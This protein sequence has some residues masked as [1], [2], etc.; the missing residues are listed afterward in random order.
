M[1][2][3]SQALSQSEDD[4]FSAQFLQST[5]LD[6]L[7]IVCCHAIWRGGQHPDTNENE[8]LADWIILVRKS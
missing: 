5:D 7:I 1:A 3:F 2:S 4:V 8:W 6:H